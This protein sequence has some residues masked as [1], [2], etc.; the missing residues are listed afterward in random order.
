MGL[1][2][3]NIWS[4]MSLQMLMKNWKSAGGSKIVMEWKLYIMLLDT[5]AQYCSADLWWPAEHYFVLNY[6]K[7]KTTVRTLRVYDYDRASRLWHSIRGNIDKI[8]ATNGNDT[9]DCIPLSMSK[10]W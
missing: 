9:K 6:S 5:K 2:Q 7:N 3:H 1:E 10:L 4:K 8:F